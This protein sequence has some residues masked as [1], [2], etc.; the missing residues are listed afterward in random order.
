MPHRALT[1]GAALVAY[2]QQVEPIRLAVNRLL[3][4]ADPILRAERERHISGRVAS[5]RMDLLERRFAA[6]TVAIAA[7]SPPTGALRG[8]HAIYAH[9]YVQEDAYLSALVNGLAEGRLDELPNTQAE[10]RAAI[11]QWR[12]GLAVLAL[13]AGVTLPDDLQQAGRGEV[14]PAV[15]GS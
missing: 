8:L 13:Q 6:Y 10:Q 7:I 15:S 14:A 9:S 4:G 3:E 5:A 2:M 11:I 12:T 1:S